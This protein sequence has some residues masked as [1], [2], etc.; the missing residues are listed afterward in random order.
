MITIDQNTAQPISEQLIEQLRYRIVNGIHKVGDLLPSTRTLANQL[1]IS[2]HTVRKVYQEL[3]KEGLLEAK[4]GSGYRVLN[5]EPLSHTDRMERGASIAAKTLKQLIG[6]GLDDNEIQYL[7]EE[8]FALLENESI[9]AK[10]VF[11]ALY[12]ELAEEGAELLTRALQQPV[13]AATPAQGGFDPDTDMVIAEASFLSQA[14]QLF[15]RSDGIGVITFPSARAMDRIA[16]LLPSD[17]L[18]LVTYRTE[19]IPQLIGYIQQQTGFAGPIIAGSIEQGTRHLNQFLND[20]NLI[21][22]T[23]ASRRGLYAW[24]K[25]GIPHVELSFSFSEESLT[26]IRQSLP[27]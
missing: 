24:L 25:S 23:P 1:G 19:S 9:H 11:V 16:R 14:M 26:Q 5:A 8:Q 4:K 18:G 15:P 3:E 6:L 27:S 17:T 10:I 21:A 22:F 7:I 12:R 20:A 13:D 2:F